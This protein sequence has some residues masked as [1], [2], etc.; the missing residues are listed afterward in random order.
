MKINETRN[1]PFDKN[2]MLKVDLKVDFF[3][4]VVGIANGLSIF[5]LFIGVIILTIFNYANL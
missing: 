2:E 3:N 1:Q 5:S 4:K